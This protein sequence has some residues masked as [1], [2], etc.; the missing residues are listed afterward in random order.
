MRYLLSFLG[1][2]LGIPAAVSATDPI[3]ANSSITEVTVFL[4]SAQISREAQI[5]VRKGENIVRFSG[6]ATGI[7][8]NSVQAAAPDI[9]LLNSVSHEVNYQQ[10][11]TASPRVRR[12]QDSLATSQKRLAFLKKEETVLG[13][14]QTMLLKNQSIAG[15]E[16]GLSVEELEKAADFLR[17][18]LTNINDRQL[19]IMQEKRKLNA[20][21]TRIKRQLSE[22]N[23]RRNQPSNDIVVKLRS[24]YDRTITVGIRYIA[25]NAG[26]T[27]R[28]DLRAQDTD[29]PI[30]LDYRADV[31]QTTGVDWKEVS[32][33]LSSGNP[34]LGGTKPQLR[35]WLL[36]TARLALRGARAQEK[37]GY[38]TDGMQVQSADSVGYKAVDRSTLADYTTVSEGMLSAEFAI[39][40]RQNVTSG[41]RPQQVSIQESELPASYRYVAVPKLDVDAFLTARVVDWESL[42]L[43]PGKVNIF[44]QGTYV[45]KAAL[46]PQSTLDTLDFSLGRDAK[47][48]IKRELLKE[49][50][51]RR[52]LGLNRERT[53]GYEITVRNTKSSP[54][55][56]QLLDQLPLSQDSKITVE[57]VEISGAQYDE[58]TGKLTWNLKLQPAETQKL[59]LIFTV[60]H[61]KKSIVRGI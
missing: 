14:E 48:M 7:D 33:T 27:P 6:L 56:L 42:N 17:L 61:P 45:T 2:L 11:L 59:R 20:T 8:P 25:A 15:T 22:L 28:Y 21:R 35:P 1:L 4:Q 37:S 18:R 43:L 30:R 19:Q 24:E 49:F 31:Y 55:D 51:R 5:R 12:L 38:Y 3:E 40:I 41:G 57:A 23:Q 47:V 53:F 34:N 29:A 52:T 58:A 16:T 10:D 36:S 54:I 32:L 13:Q 9:V 60:K 50:N 46:D 26:W 44:F 39:K